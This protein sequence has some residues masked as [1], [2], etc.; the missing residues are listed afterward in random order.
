MNSI[1]SVNTAAHQLLQLQMCKPSIVTNLR[2]M[3]RLLHRISVHECLNSLEELIAFEE[4]P[5]DFPKL[6]ILDVSHNSIPFVHQ[7][8]VRSNIV[9]ESVY[10]CVCVRVC[11]YRSQYPIYICSHRHNV[12]TRRRDVLDAI[13][14][15]TDFVLSSRG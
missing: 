9:R 13:L 12:R 3:G 10:V 14:S 4:P 2:E 8:I 7:S 1:T 5:I 6:E 11:E 15:K